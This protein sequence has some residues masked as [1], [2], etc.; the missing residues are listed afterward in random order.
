[1]GNAKNYVETLMK[2]CLNRRCVHLVCS[3]GVQH[4]FLYVHVLVCFPHASTKTGH[5]QGVPTLKK[6][7]LKICIKRWETRDCR[8]LTYIHTYIHNAYIHTYIVQQS[9]TSVAVSLYVYYLPCVEMSP[10][11]HV[12]KA[13]FVHS[14][15]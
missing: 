15:S 13:N 4:T 1:M 2:F 7:L 11:S 3:V 5:L 8:R 12:T 9:T 14:F 10:F 6:E